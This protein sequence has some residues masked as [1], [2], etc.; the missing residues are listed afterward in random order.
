MGKKD[1]KTKKFLSDAERFAS[2]CNA[3]LYDGKEVIKACD[4]HELDTTGIIMPF[5]KGK[6]SIALQKTRDLLK[7]SVCMR[8]GGNIYAIFGIENQ[9][10]IHYA[11]P[12]RNML[13]NAMAYI[14]QADAVEKRH[15]ENKDVTGDEFLSGFGKEDKLGPVIT[16]T[17]YWGTK[18]WDGPRTL[19]EMLMPHDAKL[20]KYLDKSSI[21]LFS[22]VDDETYKKCNEE[23]QTV[24]AALHY[25]NDADKLTKL[26]ENEVYENLPRE[27]AEI[28]ADI[29]GA[30]MPVKRKNGGY[31]M[32]RA[33][34]GAM[35]AKR[36]EGLKE[37]LEEG[38]KEGDLKCIIKLVCQ[39]L[40]KGKSVDQIVD[41]TES[42]PEIIQPIVDAAKK[43]AS[44]LN[45]PDVYDKI[46]KVVACKPNN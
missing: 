42:T 7:E 41:E 9:S 8:D 32:Q 43:F 29:L 46:Y 31:N 22:V 38:L 23:L 39:K 2:I 34:C 12:I 45:N 27:L 37:G 21:N 17:V 13:Y 30:K 10:N 35:E 15:K 44:E 28:L 36:E 6:K 14:I 33:A 26:M 4:L 20:D 11:M 25:S 19:A 18:P 24:F 3:V 16:I 5:G 1:K 40:L